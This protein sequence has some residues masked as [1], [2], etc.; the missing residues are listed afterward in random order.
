M[1]GNGRGLFQAL[2][3][4]SFGGKRLFGKIGVFVVLHSY[5]LHPIECDARP[6]SSVLYEARDSLF[7]TRTNQP[8]F[9]TDLRFPRGEV[10]YCGVLGSGTV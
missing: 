3:Q 8:L 4:L 1:E 9:K 10:S 6:K 5:S 7:T 2:L